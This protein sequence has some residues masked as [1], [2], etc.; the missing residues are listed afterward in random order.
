M[1]STD[2]TVRLTQ[3]EVE[4]LTLAERIERGDAEAIYDAI[5]NAVKALDLLRESIADNLTG[6][7][8]T[9]ARLAE[10]HAKRKQDTASRD[11]RRTEW[12]RSHK[13]RIAPVNQG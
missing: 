10:V 7:P 4:G 13:L 9:L 3:D 8:E 11:A 6:D 2:C 12:Q 5:V 1:R